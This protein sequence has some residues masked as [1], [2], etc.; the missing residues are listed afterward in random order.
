MILFKKYPLNI[1]EMA[2]KNSPILSRKKNF[3]R[4][5]KEIP[6]SALEKSKFP[7]LDI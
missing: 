2:K 5:A 6:K 3:S 7:P 1:V 4:K